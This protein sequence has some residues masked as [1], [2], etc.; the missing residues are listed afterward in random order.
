MKQKKKNKKP[1][2]TTNSTFFSSQ[3]DI[4]VNKSNN[5]WIILI[6]FLNMFFYLSSL[7]RF[8][9]YISGQ[10]GMCVAFLLYG[11]FRIIII[12]IIIMLVNLIWCGWDLCAERNAFRHIVL[13]TYW[14]RYVHY[15]FLFKKP[16]WNLYSLF[17]FCFRAL[18]FWSS[19]GRLVR[20]RVCV[21]VCVVACEVIRNIFFYWT[22]V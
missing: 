4:C 21:R 3:W 1:T 19:N 10:L 18:Y 13:Y 7:V 15:T 2:T 5:K 6:T 20:V 16:I 12:S 22:N 17:K 8:F 9:V 11:I 14:R